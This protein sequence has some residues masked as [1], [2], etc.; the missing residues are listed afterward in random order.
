MLLLDIFHWK[1]IYMYFFF[2][3]LQYTGEL[4]YGGP[5]YVRLLVMTYDML[6]S[7]SMHIKYVSYVCIW[8]TMHMTYKFR[9][10]F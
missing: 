2:A 1:I 8:Q 6:G 10:G 3:W 9:Q 7:S 5:L 4:A